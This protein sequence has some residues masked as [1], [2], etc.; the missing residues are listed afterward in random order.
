MS[1]SGNI[2]TS[3]SGSS[4]GLTLELTANAGAAD[5][6]VGNSVSDQLS[7]LLSKYITS[8]LSDNSI[9]SVPEKIAELEARATELE[10]ET[11]SVEDTIAGIEERYTKQF[12][13]LEQLSISLKSTSGLIDNLMEG[14][15]AD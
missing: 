12:T 6:F 11:E 1:S 9:K 15:Y 13:A 3:A 10:T 5:I 7:E 4:K 2:L 8:S 14:M